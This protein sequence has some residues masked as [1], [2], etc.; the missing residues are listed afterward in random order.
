MINEFPNPLT[1]PR[2]DDITGL[3]L[4]H[5]ALLQARN[6]DDSHYMAMKSP[7][8]VVT[9]FVNKAEVF[10]FFLL[11]SYLLTLHFFPLFFRFI[12]ILDF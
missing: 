4:C 9:F 11:L 8:Q 5:V 3:K 2:T 1:I 6:S 12:C 7:P 10:H